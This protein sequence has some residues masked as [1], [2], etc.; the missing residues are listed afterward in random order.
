MGT[1]SKKALKVILGATTAFSLFTIISHPR[2]KVYKNIPYVKV[3]NI[4]VLPNLRIKR[5]EK[6]YHIHHW[7]YWSSLYTIFCLEKKEF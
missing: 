3:R 5:K 7:L 6:I 1:V 2:S 4:D